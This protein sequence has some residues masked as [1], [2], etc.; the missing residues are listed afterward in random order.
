MAI[1]LTLVAAALWAAASLM[2]MAPAL[3]EPTPDHERCV[4][5]AAPSMTVNPSACGSQTQ[6]ARNLAKW[7][8]EA[9]K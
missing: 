7:G 9:Y 4:V 1:Y 8:N 5:G 3:A 2:Q 6:Y